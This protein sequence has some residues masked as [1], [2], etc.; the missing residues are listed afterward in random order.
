[1]SHLA[2]SVLIPLDHLVIC[3]LVLVV[4]KRRA[5]GRTDA[6]LGGYQAAQVPKRLA[7]GAR[8]LRQA[9]DVLESQVDDVVGAGAAV[10][11]AAGQALQAGLGVDAVLAVGQV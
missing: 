5:V 11:V 1:M 4:I 6:A 10:E 8:V 7:Y 2:Q 9:L 3:H